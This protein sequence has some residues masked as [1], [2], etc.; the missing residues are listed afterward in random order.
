[1]TAPNEKHFSGKTLSC[2][3][4]LSLC[5]SRKRFHDFDSAFRNWQVTAIYPDSPEID[6]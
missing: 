1:L 6:G 5:N 3:D 4:T 2:N